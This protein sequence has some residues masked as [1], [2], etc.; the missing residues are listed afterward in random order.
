MPHVIVKLYAG[1]SEEQKKRLAAAVTEALMSSL[2][3]REESVSVAI[4]DIAPERWTDEVYKPDIL[5]KPDQIYKRPG[6]NPVG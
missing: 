4:E 2:S 3:Y 1:K 6:Y 5:E